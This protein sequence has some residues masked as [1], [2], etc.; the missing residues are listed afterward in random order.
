MKSKWNQTENNRRRR[1]EQD[2]LEEE[3]R[4][5]Q[6]INKMNEDF[7]RFV[8]VVEDNVKGMDFDQPYRKLGFHGVPFRSSV[9]VQPTTYCLVQLVEPPFFVLTL[10]EVEIAYFERVQVCRLLSFGWF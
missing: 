6:M 8:K 10:A 5:R 9:F 2:E 1:G 4:E 3:Q 7:K